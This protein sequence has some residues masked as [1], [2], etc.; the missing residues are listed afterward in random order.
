MTN[1]IIHLS[2]LAIAALCFIAQPAVAQAPL[3]K[4]GVVSMTAAGSG[5]NLGIT[6]LLAKAFMTRHPGVEIKVPG[7]IGTKGAI[8]AIKDNAI[9]FG[10][11]SRPLKDS[12]QS[13]E[14]T[15]LAYARTPIVIAANPSVKDENITGEDLVA[16][17]AGTKTKWADGNEIIVQSREAFDSGFSTI[18]KVIKGFKEACD[19]SRKKESWATYFTDQDA[20]QALANTRFAIGVTDIGM[21][22]TEGLSI[23]PLKLNQIEPSIEN[24]RT[25]TYPLVRTLSILYSPKN[26]PPEGHAFIDFIFSAEGGEILKAHGYL[27]LDKTP[28]P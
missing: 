8:T 13:P 23:K 11:I 16:I 1:A 4:D 28:A 22:A 17:Y 18:E 3:E 24:V 2:L 21:I 27:P 25:G 26:L 15:A 6:T 10:L 5:V 14:I 19:E 7:S 9:T 20:N 12:E